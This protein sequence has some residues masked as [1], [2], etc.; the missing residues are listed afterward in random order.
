MA[1]TKGES[2]DDVTRVVLGLDEPGVAEEVMHFLDRSGRARVVATASDERQLAEAVR[3]LEPD[4]IVASPGLAGLAGSF[5]GS[6]LLALDT[7]ESVRALRGAIRAGARGF[8]VWP[9]ERDELAGATARALP[10]ATGVPGKR[11]SVIA[12]YG[13]RGGSGTTFLATHLAAALARR[14]RSCVL[15]DLDLA[16]ADVTHAVGAPTEEPVRTLADVVP[17]VGELSTRHLDEIL[18]QHASG[19]RVLLAPGDQAVASRIDADAVR[20][21][22][23][24][25]ATRA[26]VVVLH[27]PRGMDDVT[28]VG[29]NA[30]A[31]VVMVLQ[32]DVLSFRAAKRAIS[33]MR[34]DD[35]CELVVNAARRGEIV[36]ADVERAFGRAPAAVIPVD[37]NAGSAQDRGRLLPFRGRT[38]RAI[39][40][41][42]AHL[43]ETGS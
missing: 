8:Y 3:Q 33:A 11:G 29:L 37:R 24:A 5:S 17:L 25:V 15:V 28:R 23:D 9:A 2:V 42:A 36:P 4:A 40:R 22:I 27:I 19:F 43:L 41:L 7:A 20:S 13:P 38:G 39:D 32:L 35:R 14:D 21:T 30:A 31:K 34:I 10:S 6:V 1:W 18:W 12:V 26:D 16:F